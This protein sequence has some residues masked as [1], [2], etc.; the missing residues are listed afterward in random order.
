MENPKPFF[1]LAK[2]LYPGN[3]APTPSHRRAP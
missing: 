1:V 3:F 2:E